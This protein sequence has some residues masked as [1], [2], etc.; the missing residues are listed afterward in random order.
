[1]NV[2]SQE[3]VAFVFNITNTNP[4]TNLE[5]EISD[6][7]GDVDAFHFGIPVVKFGAAY[8][9]S[10]PEKRI[11]HM[12]ERVS[13]SGKTHFITYLLFNFSFPGLSIQQRRWRILGLLNT[14]STRDW[15]HEDNTVKKTKFIC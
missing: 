8:K 3:T 6:V 9:F 1:M 7:G 2:K 11:I 10:D 5:F 12:A 14:E 4:M 13:S 15:E